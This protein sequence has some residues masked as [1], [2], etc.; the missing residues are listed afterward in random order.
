M[1][2]LVLL[3]GSL[4]IGV[5]GY[6]G[7]A[8]LRLVDAFLNA[9]M[10]L[11]GMGPVDVLSDDAAKWFAGIYALYS[12]VVFLVVVGVVFAPVLHRILHHL[13]IDT[14]D[15]GEYADESPPSGEPTSPRLPSDR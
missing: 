3:I 1:F 14:G 8:H 10:I 15:D 2:G 5:A 6:M 13:H 4:L 12:G 7:F 9:A 11:G